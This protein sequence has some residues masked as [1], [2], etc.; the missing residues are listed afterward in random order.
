M[1]WERRF[2]YEK[3]EWG[4][5]VE[6]KR[7]WYRA[8]EKLRP[9]GVRAH[10]ANVHGGSPGCVSVIG[11]GRNVVIGFIQEWQLWHDRRARWRTNFIDWTKWV[12]GIFVAI[13]IALWLR[14]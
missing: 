14:K 2:P 4:D 8:L 7:R 12:V 5:N 3:S 13:G 11:E 10:M 1:C 9:A 6:Q